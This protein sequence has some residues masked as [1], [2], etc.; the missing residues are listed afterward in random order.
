MFP[1]NQ[2]SKTIEMYSFLANG[3]LFGPSVYV[4]FLAQRFGKTPSETSQLVNNPNLLFGLGK[5][6]PLKLGIL[7]M[8]G[9]W[10]FAEQALLFSSPCI[11]K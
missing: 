4:N 5:K 11:R 7:L 3:A 1:L 2:D 8:S 9:L 6:I 10:S